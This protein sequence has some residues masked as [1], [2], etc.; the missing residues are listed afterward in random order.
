MAALKY[1]RQ[2]ES[3]KHYLM[4]TKEHPTADTVYMHVKKEFPN[5]SLGTV[6]RNLNFLVEH[7]EAIQIDCG[8]GF[9]HFDG[10]HFLCEECGRLLDL[11]LD[12]K[13][14]EEVN[15]LA[16]KNFDGAITSSS[17]LFFGKCGDCI[18]KS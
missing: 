9:V 11:D 6:Y 8:D 14:I 3:I 16:G 2:R 1:S 13:S 17:T 18:K 5:I 10:N 15:C 12:M 4:T 7:G